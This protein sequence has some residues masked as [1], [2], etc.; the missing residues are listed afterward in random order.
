[1]LVTSSQS[2]TTPFSGAQSSPPSSG[3]IPSASST[4]FPTTTTLPTDRL[5][6]IDQALSELCTSQADH[7]R[8]LVKQ[9]SD[10]SSL[11]DH[12]NHTMQ[13]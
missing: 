3:A 12:I 6:A 1:M 7:N 8:L 2:G 10:A 11:S 4:S 5:D 13:S 9:T